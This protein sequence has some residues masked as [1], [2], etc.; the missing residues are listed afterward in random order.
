MPVG[1]IASKPN[2]IYADY[3]QINLTFKKIKDTEALLSYV[4]SCF[5]QIQTVAQD[6]EFWQ[7]QNLLRPDI[8]IGNQN[9]IF[10]NYIT[11]EDK[12]VLHTEEDTVTISAYVSATLI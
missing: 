7:M 12:F 2:Y 3:K 11:V 5:S 6:S 10:K 8:G 1:L 9:T 4:K